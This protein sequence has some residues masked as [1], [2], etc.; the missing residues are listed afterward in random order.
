M[1]THASCHGYQAIGTDLPNKDGPGVC[2]CLRELLTAG[3]RSLEGERDDGTDQHYPSC[4][5]EGEVIGA[6]HVSRARQEQRGTEASHRRCGKYASVDRPDIPR[7]VVC[8]GQRRHR[9]VAAPVTRR[10]S[11]GETQNNAKDPAPST[12]IKRKAAACIRNIARN[13][14]APP[15]LSER[16]GHTSRPAVSDTAT[17]ITKPEATAAVAPPIEPAIALASE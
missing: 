3:A 2:Q 17:I 7:A 15:I 4:D 11:R 8:G 14:L 1:T 10:Y 12:G 13:T 9:R 16:I 5:V 6:R